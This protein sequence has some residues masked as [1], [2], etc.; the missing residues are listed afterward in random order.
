MEG[1]IKIMKFSL[2][3]LFFLLFYICAVSICFSGSPSPIK[4]SPIKKNY[5]FRDK[6]SVTI[7]NTTSDTIYSLG[8]YI[9]KKQLN[10]WL[11]LRLDPLCPCE[12]ECEKIDHHLTGKHSM[13]L[14]WDFK[15][16]N[17]RGL[18]CFIAC[19]GGV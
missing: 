1:R 8:V 11:T 10:K 19:A 2:K 12:A 15:Y 18:G 4:F 9:Q 17:C 3:L 14:S 13:L 5:T 6:I 16:D 7:T